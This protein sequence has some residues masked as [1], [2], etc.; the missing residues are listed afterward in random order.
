MPGGRPS[1]YTKEVA[2][3]CRDYLAGN[4]DDGESHFPS[5]VALSRHLDVVLSTIDKWRHDEDKPEFSDILDK[6]KARQREILIHKGLAGDFNSAIC[7]LVLGKHGLH[8]K[9]DE[10]QTGD[11]KITVTNKIIK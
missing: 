10:N 4:W 8:D 7:K 2:Q 3:K 11:I 1:K 5:Q 9:V 6:I